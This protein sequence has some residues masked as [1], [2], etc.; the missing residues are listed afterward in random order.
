MY[1]GPEGSSNASNDAKVETSCD[2]SLKIQDS[3]G[4]ATFGR[5]IRDKLFLYQTVWQ[6][7]TH[8]DLMVLPR[9]LMQFLVHTFGLHVCNCTEY[10][11]EEFTIRCHLNYQSN[12]PNFDWMNVM[13]EHLLE[14]QKRPKYAL[15]VLQQLL[16]MHLQLSHIDWLCNV[17]KHELVAIPCYF[18]NGIGHGHIQLYRHQQLKVHALLFQSPIILQFCKQKLDTCGQQNLLI[19]LQSIRRAIFSKNPKIRGSYFFHSIFSNVI[20]LM[21]FFLKPL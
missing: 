7:S 10:V 3:T 20:F 17:L 21:Q 19:L 5:I 9:E 16:S 8:K 6:T 18:K 12:G 4:H 13:Y 14:N 11:R 1:L 2:H 15:V